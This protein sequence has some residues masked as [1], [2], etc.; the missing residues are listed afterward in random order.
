MTDSLPEWVPEEYDPDAPLAER[1]PVIAEME[2]GIEIH[3]EDKR[4]TIYVVHQPQNLKELP[5]DGLQL[6][7]GP[8]TGYWSHEIV[9]PGGDHEAYLRK[10]DPDQD[11]DAYVATRETVGKDIDVRVY[12]VDADRFE[13]DTPEATA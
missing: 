7:C 11:Y 8:R 10:V 3:V 6:D 1:L 12:G 2:G 9:V 13:D 4:G 5:S